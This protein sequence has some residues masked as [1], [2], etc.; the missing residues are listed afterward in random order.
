MA[1]D[2]LWRWVEW[3]KEVLGGY[4]PSG[5]YLM[6]C[7]GGFSGIK[8]CKVFFFPSEWDLMDCVG[9]LSGRKRC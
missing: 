4:L 9:G 2:G 3:D 1:F 8:R 5:W 7:V 6:D